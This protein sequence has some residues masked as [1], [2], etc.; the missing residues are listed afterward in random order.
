MA[1]NLVADRMRE[2]AFCKG[3]RSKWFQVWGL[4]LSFT[5]GFAGLLE[6]ANSFRVKTVKGFRSKGLRVKG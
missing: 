6:V 3:A 5:Q 4:G 1:Q 2:K